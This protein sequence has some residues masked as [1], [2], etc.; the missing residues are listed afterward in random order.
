MLFIIPCY[1]PAPASLPGLVALLAGAGWLL[2]LLHVLC[3]FIICLVSIS[4]SPLASTQLSFC[5]FYRKS[6]GS[7][8]A[9]L[10][11]VSITQQLIFPIM[12]KPLP[13]P[14]KG[15]GGRKQEETGRNRQARQARRGRQGWGLEEGEGGQKLADT[16]HCTTARACAGPDLLPFCDLCWYF[17][18]SPA[19]P[20]G[21]TP[22]HTPHTTPSLSL[23]HQPINHII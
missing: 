5:P 20:K 3:S 21:C 17:H 2:M 1:L 9:C 8:M 19:L 16:A 6:F 12:K 4:L 22:L 11:S 23:S 18:S 14:A 15:A 13:H 7:L 10:F